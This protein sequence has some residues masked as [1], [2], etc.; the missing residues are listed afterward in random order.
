MIEPTGIADKVNMG[1]EIK[2]EMRNDN[3]DFALSNGVVY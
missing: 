2:G 1:N 3:K